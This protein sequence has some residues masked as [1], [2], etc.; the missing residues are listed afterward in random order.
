MATASSRSRAPMVRSPAPNRLSRRRIA[1]PTVRPTLRP[2]STRRFGCTSTSAW[3][4]LNST[5]GHVLVAGLATARGVRK[6]RLIRVPTRAPP[7]AGPP[8][9]P[10]IRAPLLAA[11][12]LSSGQAVAS[13]VTAL[14]TARAA[15]GAG[16]LPEAGSEG[17]GMA[18]E[19]DELADPCE[20]DG[21]GGAVL[22]AGGAFC[23]GESTGTGRSAGAD[24]SAARRRSGDRRRPP[25]LPKPGWP[26]P[27]A[28]PT[29]H[30]SPK[31]ASRARSHQPERLAP[32]HRRCRDRE[33]RR[34]L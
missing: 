19:A 31:P 17:S 23:V 7:L 8:R 20:P 12:T 11:A 29:R 28:P 5:P 15:A 18:P 3:S 14:S 16:S 26:T 2:I 1:W 13:G 24:W 9:P 27:A 21:A 33:A 22:S 6:R 34:R 30:C 4:M 25:D 32:H 10:W